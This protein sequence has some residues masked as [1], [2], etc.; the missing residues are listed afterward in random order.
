VEANVFRVRRETIE[1]TVDWRK[2]G[3]LYT[4]PQLCQPLPAGSRT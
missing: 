2:G 3:G 4:A 1:A